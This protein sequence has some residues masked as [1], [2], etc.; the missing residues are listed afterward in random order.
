MFTIVYIYNHVYIY[1]YTYI[2]N[3]SLKIREASRFSI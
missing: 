2:D 1:I 3:M